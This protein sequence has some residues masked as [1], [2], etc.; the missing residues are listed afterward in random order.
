M[1]PR[2]KPGADPRTVLVDM[3]DNP[4]LRALMQVV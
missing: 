2:Y 3:P 4:A 1:R